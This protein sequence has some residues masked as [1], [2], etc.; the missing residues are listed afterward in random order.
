[1]DKRLIH[2]VAG[3]GKTTAIL[4]DLQPD[5][6]S[7]VLTY[8]NQ[9]LFSLETG[10]R[11][12][13]DGV[14]PATIELRTYFSFLYSYCLRPYVSHGLRD[15]G[16]VYGPVPKSAQRISK[17]ELRHF[18]SSNRYLYGA[19]AGKLVLETNVLR[20][21]KDSLYKHFDRIYVDEVQDFASNDFNLLLEL[22]NSGVSMLCVG[23]FFQHT[24][25]TSRDGNTRVNLHRK[26][27][28]AY[29][30]EF[31]K[32]KFSVDIKTLSRSRRCSSSVCSFITGKLGVDIGSARTDLTEVQF[33]DHVEDIE[34]V[35]HDPKIV[36]LFL[37]E[38]SLYN[39]YSNNW[40]NSKGLDNYV[41]VCVVL[42]KNIMMQLKAGGANKLKP[43][44]KNKLYVACSRARGNLYFV[45]QKQLK[46][47]RGV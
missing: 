7:L 21:V 24:F 38:H 17:K 5:R 3:A 31:R 27:Q 6:R 13:F 20:K 16:L 42:S 40:G 9:N 44:T 15:H 33:L 30:D 36:K 8:T 23:D 34:R 26:G 46:K 47:L 22:A 4:N 11:S 45:D 32:A 41:D 37:Q 29:L 18:M 43:M 28:E 25:D 14:V 2:A 19:R 10:I 35:Y 12:R 39:C 1:M